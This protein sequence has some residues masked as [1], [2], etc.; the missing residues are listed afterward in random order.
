VTHRKIERGR[1]LGVTKEGD[2]ADGDNEYAVGDDG[3]KEPLAESNDNN[4]Y[5]YDKD[6]NIADNNNEYTI[7]KGGVDE[8]LDKGDDEYDT[9]SAACARACPESQRPSVPSG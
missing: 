8:P 1:G 4:D 6:G 9:L 7:G 2:I 5:K 3:N